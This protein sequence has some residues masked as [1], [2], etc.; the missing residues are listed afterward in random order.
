MESATYPKAQYRGNIEGFSL[1]AI[2]RE[3]REL[4]L[5][6][7]MTIHGVTRDL[8]TLVS[9]NRDGET[10]RMVSDFILMPEDFDIE[11]P[12]I[13]F[14]KI[15]EEVAVDATFELVGESPGEN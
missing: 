13:L 4:R 14:N 9:L 7:Q 11:V 15:A 5:N 12:S 3:P 2:G 10:I 6:G 1:D 8:T